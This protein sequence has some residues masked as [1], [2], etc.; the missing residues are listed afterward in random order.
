[1]KYLS[2]PEALDLLVV[3]S[4]LEGLAARLAAQRITEAS[5]KALLRDLEALSTYGGSDVLELSQLNDQ[6]H[7]RIALIAN[8]KY[9]LE[10]LDTIRVKLRLATTVLYIS[11]RRRLESAEEHRALVQAILAGDEGEAQ[12]IAEEHVARTCEDLKKQIEKYTDIRI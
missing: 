5:K 11:P 7:R 8:N 9:L 12:K 2:P 10:V 6:F 1:M 3:R 4:C